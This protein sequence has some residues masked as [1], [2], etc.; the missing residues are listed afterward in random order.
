MLSCSGQGLKM[1]NRVDNSW[2]QSVNDRF[3]QPW[4]KGSTQALTGALLGR[5]FATAVTGD[6]PVG[7]GEGLRMAGE[8]FT[9]RAGMGAAFGGI[10][11]VGDVASGSGLRSD[12]KETVETL[13]KQV[14]VPEPLAETGGA[15]GAALDTFEA[16]A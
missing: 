1:A 7:V 6:E 14:G 13:A 8:T 16:D 3:E 4:M 5:D 2:M 11:V 15:F 10:P 9:K 12:T